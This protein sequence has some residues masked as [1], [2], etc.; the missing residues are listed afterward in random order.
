MTMRPFIS[1][2]GLTVPPV[3]CSTQAA[4]FIGTPE[5]PFI[6]DLIKK[7]NGSSFQAQHALLAAMASCDPSN[8]CPLGLM[9]VWEGIDSMETC[10][11]ALH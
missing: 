1:Y 5:T 8:G 2:D 7:L 10:I 4:P 3:N 9:K 11:D 6:K